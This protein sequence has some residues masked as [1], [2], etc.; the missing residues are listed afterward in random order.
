[1]IT[2]EIKKSDNATPAAAILT[3]NSGYLDICSKCGSDFSKYAKSRNNQKDMRCTGECEKFAPIVN[4]YEER[5]RI[6]KHDQLEFKNNH[7]VKNFLTKKNVISPAKV[8]TGIV[9]IFTATAAYFLSKNKKG[10]NY[11][12]Y[13]D[14]GDNNLFI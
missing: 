11:K 2:Q 10:N 5:I 12:K 8:V 14:D 9:G 13:E 6:K 4:S 1:M 7:K 3:F